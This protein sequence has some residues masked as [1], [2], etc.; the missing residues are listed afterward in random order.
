MHPNLETLIQLQKIEIQIK[1]LSEA[2]EQLPHRLVLMEKK[3]E[4]T[5]DLLE[6]RKENIL[7]IEVNRRQS[8]SKIKV[9]EEKI[10]Q[11]RGQLSDV[12]TNEQ[13]KALL[14]EIDFQDRKIRK[15]EDDIL[16][17]MEKEEKFRIDCRELEEKHSGE[18]SQVNEEKKVAHKAGEKMK[19]KL[20][21]SEKERDTLIELISPGIYKTYRSISDVRKGIALARATESCQGCHVRIRPSILSRVMGNEEILTC[22]SCNRILYWQPEAP[23]EISV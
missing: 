23:Y 8:E 10:S 4:G 17:D 6:Q 9:I 11:Y 12:K 14:Q 13:Y 15:I 5:S 22:E 21:Q 16:I 18:V 2:L 7:Q 1:E 19:G 3:L 20:E